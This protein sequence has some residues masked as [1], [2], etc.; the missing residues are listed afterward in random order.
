MEGV[1]I[2]GFLDGGLMACWLGGNIMRGGGFGF[3]R[4]LIVGMA[5]ALLGGF[6]LNALGI[7]SGSFVG[8]LVTGT[9]AG[10]MLLFITGRNLGHRSRIKRLCVSNK[11][12]QPVEVP[13]NIE[14]KHLV[15]ASLPSP[16]IHLI[17]RYQAKILNP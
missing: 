14:V 4:N 6:L 7:V 10:G 11:T 9:I 13:P 3:F 8:A 12:P 16:T 5:G 1:S 2:I 15:S 17:P